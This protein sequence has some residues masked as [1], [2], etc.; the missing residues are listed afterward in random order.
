MIETILV[1]LVAILGSN[2]T[3]DNN[4]DD[5]VSNNSTID[6]PE[7][8][9]GNESGFRDLLQRDPRCELDSMFEGF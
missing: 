9:Y 4:D 5:D 6:C 1:M 8:F 7:N 2:I 3:D